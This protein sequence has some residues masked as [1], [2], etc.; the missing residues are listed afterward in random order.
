MTVLAGVFSR[1][2]HRPVDPQICNELHRLVSRHPDDK[3]A[4]FEDGNTYLVKVDIGAY[5]RPGFHISDRGSASMLAGEPLFVQGDRGGQ[6]RDQDLQ[7]L[8]QAL[9]R[10]DLSILA[11]ARGIFCAVHY[12]PE[13]RKL[14]L[15]VDKLGLRAL[16]YFVD[17]RCVIF[18]TALRILESLDALPKQMDLRAVTELSVFSYPLADR[19]PY[20]DILLMRQAEVL[21]FDATKLERYQYWRWDCVAPSDKSEQALLQKAYE[22]FS[23]AV[24]CRLR[25]DTTAFAFLSGGLDSRCVTA[26]LRERN[27][28]VY[29]VNFAPP[30]TQDRAL[31]ADFSAQAG[32]LHEEFK[33]DLAQG[34]S[35]NWLRSAMHTWA[36][37]TPRLALPVPHPDLVWGGHGGSL[38]LGHPFPHSAI[39]PMR[40]NRVD[41]AAEE[42]LCAERFN[43]VSRLLAPRVRPYLADVPRQGLIQELQ[44]LDCE[45]PGRAVFLFYMFN[46][47]RRHVGDLFEDIDLKRF[48]YH[49]P[50]FDSEFVQTIMTVPLD[51][52]LRHRFYNKWLNL[53]PEAVLAVPWQAYP[54]HEPC[55]IAVPVGLTNQWED[56]WAPQVIDMQKRVRLQR[57]REMLQAPNFPKS[58][59]NKNALRIATWVYR[60]GLRDYA[61]VLDAASTYYKYWCSSGGNYL[62]LTQAS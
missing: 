52:C 22:S 3:R 38:G 14:T 32:T 30:A 37:S 13:R 9:D 6:E 4:V 24:G 12:H 53:F 46:E 59:L 16:Y 31:A 29:T 61:Y 27:T 19:T 17:R 58:V 26:A 57:A 62:P 20:A 54:G 36:R 43:V 35:L 5:G 55:P 33:P 49:L 7:A 34:N 8:H 48:E 51:L 47:Q 23:A 44:A 40:E 18:S 11:T 60:L 1:D 42:V 15:I 41:A 10:G 39:D 2:P 21:Q 56:T 25:Q 45:D 50:F 28:T